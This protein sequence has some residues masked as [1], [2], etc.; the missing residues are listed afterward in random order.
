MRAALAALVAFF[1]FAALAHADDQAS[2]A[3]FAWPLDTE[4]AWFAAPELRNVPSGETIATLTDGAIK[5][6]LRE[7]AAARLPN[8]PERAS[9][10]PNMQA[11]F[12]I[13]SSLPKP[14]LLQVTLTDEGWIDMIQNGAYLQAKEHTGKRDCPGLRKSVRFEVKADGLTLQVSGAQKPTIGIAVR[15]I[16]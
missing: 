1:V 14:G 11:G 12:V 13:F 10:P 3:Q 9:E 7:L 8:A 16:E 4:K 2:C 5:L 6:E 15:Y